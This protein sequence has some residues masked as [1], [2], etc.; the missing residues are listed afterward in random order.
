MNWWDAVCHTFA[1]LATGG[2]STHD[3]S[4][5]FFN[6]HPHG[7]AIEMTMSPAPAPQAKPAG[8]K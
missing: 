7:L 5:E 2:F 1:T 4:V 8:G 6:N 3:K